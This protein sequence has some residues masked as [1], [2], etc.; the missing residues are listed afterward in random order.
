MKQL[1]FIEELS[2]ELM[3]TLLIK[4][5]SI[6]KY[7]IAEAVLTERFEPLTSMLWGEHYLWNHLTVTDLN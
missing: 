1:L 3:H 7:T 4:R 5:F 6:Y 2:R